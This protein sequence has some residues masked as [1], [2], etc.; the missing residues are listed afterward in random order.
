MD[1]YSYNSA[2]VLA[3]TGS[4]PEPWLTRE[5]LA[6]IRGLLDDV[7]LSGLFQGIVLALDTSGFPAGASVQEI[8]SAKGATAHGFGPS[9]QFLCNLIERFPI[10]IVAAVRGYCVG[11]SMDLVL[12]CHARLASY[13]TSFTHA[14]AS[15]GLVTSWFGIVRLIRV[16]GRA[17][18]AQVLATNARV[19]AT[20]ALTLG[21]VDE[22]VPAADLIEAAAR[23]VAHI[24]RRRAENGNWQL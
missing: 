1:F 19:P 15:M 10:P 21:L 5:V 2:A 23:R 24:A 22:L 3:Y 7:R 14:G 11:A 17:A 6:E 8:A 12:T 16:L 9:S 13:D 20:Q 18:A 4:G